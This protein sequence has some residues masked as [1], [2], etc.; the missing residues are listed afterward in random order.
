MKRT[1]KLLLSF[2]LIVSCLSVSAFAAD[3]IELGTVSE[4]SKSVTVNFKVNGLKTGDDVTILVYKKDT[5]TTEPNEDN[6]VYINQ[7]SAENSK[8][9]FNLLSDAAEGRYEVRMGGTGIKTAVIGSF[10]ISSITYGDLDGDGDIDGFDAVWILKCAAGAELPD[11]LVISGGDVDGD[12]DI[13]G[14]DAVWV[15]KYAAGAE[16]PD[17]LLIKKK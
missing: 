14:F 3:S 1:F 7:I 17:G 10:T 5:D 11:G 8:I 16:L 2:V 9:E 6:I 4:E 15:L 13:D 12:G